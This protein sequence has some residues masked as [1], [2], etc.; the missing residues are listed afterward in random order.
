MKSLAHFNFVRTN[1]NIYLTQIKERERLNKLISKI[2]EKE[3][4]NEK[5]PDFI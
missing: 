4:N 5:N 3:K 1:Y 2:A